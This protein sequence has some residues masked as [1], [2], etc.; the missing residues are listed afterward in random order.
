MDNCN[1]SLDIDLCF[2]Y[3]Q[4]PWVYLLLTGYLLQVYE[5]V[6]LDD[7]FR[8]ADETGCRRVTRPHVL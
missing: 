3:F 1:S 5:T 4:L 7:Y 2:E 6:V 8:L